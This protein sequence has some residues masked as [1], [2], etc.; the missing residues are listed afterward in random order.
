MCS[1]DNNSTGGVQMS[2]AVMDK[3]SVDV[4]AYEMP[5]TEKLDRMVKALAAEDE[6]TGIEAAGYGVYSVSNT[7]SYGIMF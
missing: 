5:E 2:E 7:N 1:Y 6:D 3:L 4:S